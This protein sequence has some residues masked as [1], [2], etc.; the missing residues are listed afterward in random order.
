MLTPL[1]KKRATRE[2]SSLTLDENGDML[3]TATLSGARDFTI[4]YLD[5]GAYFA[6]E[7]TPT[8]ILFLGVETSDFNNFDYR[9]K[10]ILP[11]AYREN[12][13]GFAAFCAEHNIAL[14]TLC[15]SGGGF[16]VNTLTYETLDDAIHAIIDAVESNTVLTCFKPVES[17]PE[18]DSGTKNSPLVFVTGKIC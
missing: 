7:F 11:D 3:S 8:G 2:L 10:N 14:N 15:T 4:Q 13:N 5:N 1:E 17:T 12:P 9:Y 18:E 16:S 6:F